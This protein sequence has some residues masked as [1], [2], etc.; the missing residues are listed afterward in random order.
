M[1]KY[2]DIMMG[3]ILFIV[4]LIYFIM[5]FSIKLTY[6]DRIVGSRVFPQI[7]GVI[8]IGLSLWLVVSG[9]RRLRGFGGAEG[10]VQTG[11]LETGTLETRDLETEALET[12]LEGAGVERMGPEVMSE[13]IGKRECGTGWIPPA[14]KT[15]LVLVSFAVFCWLLN[16]LGFALASFLY[17]FSQMLLISGK[18][19]AVKDIVCYLIL[20]IV[21]AAGIYYLFYRGFS[22]MLPKAGWFS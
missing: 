18:K 9:V 3:T 20:S 2:K 16:K 15:L 8:L 1:K 12:G 17:L 4:G 10:A 21:L 14:V 22:L 19:L 6:I 7:C 5:S 11:A 13:R